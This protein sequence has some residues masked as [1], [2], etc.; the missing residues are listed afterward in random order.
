GVETTHVSA[1]VNV[2]NLLDALNEAVK[3]APTVSGRLSA[4]TQLTEQQKEQVT[5][6]VKNPTFDV[7]VGKDDN[8]IRR[9]SFDVKIEVPQGQSAQ[10]GGFSG[11]QLSF[12]LQ[13]ANVN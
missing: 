11:G 7:Y 10:L 8:I 13:L 1:K 6:Y 2:G 4:P 9:I 12:N 5:K 3:K